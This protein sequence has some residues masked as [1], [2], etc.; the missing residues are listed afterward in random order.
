LDYDWR[1]SSQISVQVDIPT[2]VCILMTVTCDD[3]TI[4]VHKE[5]GFFFVLSDE[6]KHKEVSFVQGAKDICTIKPYEGTLEPDNIYSLVPFTKIDDVEGKFNFL[7]YTKKGEDVK[8]NQLKDWKHVVSEKGEWSK[9]KGT[10]GGCQNHESWE[11]NPKFRL[12]LPKDEDCKFCVLLEQGSDS[13]VKNSRLAVSEFQIV[14]YSIGIG[15][16][17]YDIR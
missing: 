5:C 3:E 8:V 4:K 13:S 10:A 17:V 6:G 1:E 11:E 2:E 15:F 9:N 12:T 14:P 7:I 16:Y